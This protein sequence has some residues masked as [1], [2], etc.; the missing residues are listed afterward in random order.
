MSLRDDGTGIIMLSGPTTPRHGMQSLRTSSWRSYDSQRNIGHD[1]RFSALGVGPAGLRTT[2]MSVQ[3][4]AGAEAGA[5]I[6]DLAQRLSSINLT[7]R[8]GTPMI[9]LD[10]R[11]IAAESDIEAKAKTAQALLDR[12]PGGA[13]DSEAEELT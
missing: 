11:V 10:L 1:G 12:M 13:I 5:L 9:I 6:E 7:G 4:E 2:I 3:R 8:D